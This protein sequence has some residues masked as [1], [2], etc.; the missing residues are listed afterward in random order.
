MRRFVPA[1]GSRAPRSRT[2]RPVRAIA[3]PMESRT[4]LSVV[5]AVITPP[6]TGNPFFFTDAL[7]SGR[8]YQD[9]NIN[10]AFDGSDVPL[11]NQT[12]FVDV[13][14]DGL[15][16][17][18][19]DEITSTDSSGLYNL[20]VPPGTFN[21]RLV[22]ATGLVLEGS[23]TGLQPVTITDFQ[24]VSGKDFAEYPA[25]SVSGSVFS[26][27]NSNGIQDSGEVGVGNRTVYA[28][29][30]NNGVLD[31]ADVSTT[32][33]LA[34]NFTI[35]GLP[36]G[37]YTIRIQVPPGSQQTAPGPG[38]YQFVLGAGQAASGAVFGLT[39]PDLTAQLISAPPALMIGGV[40]QKPVLV[41]VTNVGNLPI[42]Q[43]VGITLYASPDTTFDPT[44]NAIGFL[45]GHKANLKPGQTKR[46]KVP[47]RVPTNVTTGSYHLMAQVISSEP[48]ANPANDVAVAVPT[49]TIMK[50]F[51]DLSIAY[52]A[53]PLNQFNYGRSGFV[54]VTVTNHGN[55][56]YDGFARL[57][58]FATTDQTLQNSTNISHLRDMKIKLL[59]QQSKTFLVPIAF[60]GV[61][62]GTFYL[63]SSV[64]PTGDVGDFDLVN[65]T[66][67]SNTTTTIL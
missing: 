55:V 28:D 15:P 53:Q 51:V 11:S 9:N 30:N 19:I 60:S 64:D 39:G 50:P 65:N 4:L 16:E 67:I 22:P 47:M 27:V 42:T 20:T 57:Q 38:S 26:D 36:I 35:G 17:A 25:A 7:I 63:I 46:F 6:P 61:A 31:A 58:V 54:A 3:E 49:T 40:Q 59:P 32:T 1:S 34:G 56:R 29:I 33:D 48:D 10:G 14:N 52:A 24:F 23:S 44:D 21:I 2:H 37:T 5:P 8:V 66:V 62:K 18:G 43:L 13:N 41:A 12:V 45:I